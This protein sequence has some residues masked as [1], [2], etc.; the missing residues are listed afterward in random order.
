MSGC[1][2]GLAVRH[3]HRGLVTE[4][5]FLAGLQD[6]RQEAPLPPQTSHRPS[7]GCQPHRRRGSTLPLLVGPQLQL[8]ATVLTRDA[9]CELVCQLF[10][11]LLTKLPGV[12]GACDRPRGKLTMV[13]TLHRKARYSRLHED[14]RINW[15]KPCPGWSAKVHQVP[16]GLMPHVRGGV[17]AGGAEAGLAAGPASP[18][19][20]LGVR[21][22]IPPQ[23]SFSFTPLD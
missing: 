20:A 10:H 22:Q 6:P 2:W 11:L 12:M 13:R 21:G 16:P 4:R 23:D 19:A 15:G 1:S 5:G 9:A 3:S 7:S 8:M 17:R 18:W 14:T